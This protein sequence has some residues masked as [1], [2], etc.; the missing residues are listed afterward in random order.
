MNLKYIK[1]LVLSNKVV[2]IAITFV[3]IFYMSSIM[4]MYDPTTVDAMMGY[5]E[6]LPEAMIKALN[7]QMV[8]FTFLGFIAGYY[9]GFLAMT[10]PLIFSMMFTYKVVAKTIDNNSITHLLTSGRSRLTLILHAWLTYA[11]VLACMISLLMV[12]SYS[13]AGSM[14]EGVTLDSRFIYL[15]IYLYGF[16]LMMGSLMMMFSAI[17]PSASLALGAIIGVP[18]TSMVLDMVARLGEDLSWVRFASLHTLFD[19]DKVV[20]QE[21]VVTQSG[22]MVGL[23]LL[24]LVI[25]L[26]G[27]KKRDII[28]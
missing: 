7:F 16:H 23:T 25:T 27:F 24:F 17:L 5:I 26:I 12:A 22:I 13:M 19:A 3:L 20:L 1:Y 28:V 21:S 6:A 15:N 18:L 11:V 10:F 4:M 2:W 14:F 8:D 9:Y